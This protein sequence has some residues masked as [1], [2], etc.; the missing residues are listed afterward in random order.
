MLVAVNG[1][2]I[3]GKNLRGHMEGARFGKTTPMVSRLAGKP[4]FSDQ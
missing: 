1:R 2:M 3:G 4:S